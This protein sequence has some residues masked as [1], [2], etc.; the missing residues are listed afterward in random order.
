[1]STRGVYG[2]YKNNT[3]KLTY[4]H[5]DSYP[6]CL[7]NNVLNFI[8]NMSVSELN[9]I[10]DNITLVQGDDTPNESQSVQ[11]K[12][13][14]YSTIYHGKELTWHEIIG[15]TAGDFS[16]LKD[17]F[18]FM[19]DSNDFITKSLHCEWGYIVNLNDNTLEIYKGFQKE[20]DANRYK[21]KNPSSSGYYHCKLI[22]KLSFEELLTIDSLESILQ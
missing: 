13:L 11:L 2:F 8:K 6:S 16:Y 5:Y 9:S 10:Y 20:S 22:K 18:P 19:I 17:D 15:S 12:K 1:M 14:G 7:G 4:N 21:I 3:S